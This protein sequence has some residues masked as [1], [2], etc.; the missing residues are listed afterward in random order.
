MTSGTCSDITFSQSSVGDAIFFPFNPFSG[1]ISTSD[2]GVSGDFSQSIALE[3]GDGG[4]I[5]TI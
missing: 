5:V 2:F 3:A 4:V 1:E